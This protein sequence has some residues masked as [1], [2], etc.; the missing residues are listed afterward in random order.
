[1]GR[2]VIQSKRIGVRGPS[3]GGSA[4]GLSDSHSVSRLGTPWC[5]NLMNT[6]PYLPPLEGVGHKRDVHDFTFSCLHWF[7]IT[8]V[9]NSTWLKWIMVPSSVCVCVCVSFSFS[10]PLFPLP[11]GGRRRGGVVKQGQLKLMVL[12]AGRAQGGAGRFLRQISSE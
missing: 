4:A 1:M 8:R 7:R 11:L 12:P 6:L 3:P 9:E 5:S 10:L 2:S